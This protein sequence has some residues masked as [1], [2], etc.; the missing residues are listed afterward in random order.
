[1]EIYITIRKIDSQWEFGEW[2]RKLKQW[3]CISLEGWDGAGDGRVVQ[4]G[5]D[6]CTPMAD[7]TPLQYS[8]LENPRD[9]GAW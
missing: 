5:G 2:L 6:I 9:G 4:K 3:F 7:S 8:C 1:M